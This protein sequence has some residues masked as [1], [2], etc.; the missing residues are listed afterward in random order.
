MTDAPSDRRN[1]AVSFDKIRTVLGFQAQTSLEDGIREIAEQF[2]QRGVP[3][4]PGSD[5]SN[6]ATT[7][8]SCTSSTRR[9]PALRAAGAAAE[10]RGG[11]GAQP[12]GGDVAVD[13]RGE[14]GFVNDFDFAGVKRFYAV[15]NHSGASC[16][17]GTRTAG[18]PST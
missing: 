4:L 16:A 18:K 2:A 15:R 6:V 1:Y 10:A 11:H 14:V 5:Y 9:G 8:R 13:D 12:A 17:R 7:R 3:R